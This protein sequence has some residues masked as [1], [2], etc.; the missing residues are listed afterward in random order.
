MAFFKKNLSVLLF[1][2]LVALLTLLTGNKY[3]LG[4]NS[5]DKNSERVI[6]IAFGD[7][8]TGEN[9]QYTLAAHLV[10]ECGQDCKGIFLLGDVI[11]PN[12][13][14]ALSDFQF[15]TKFEAPFANIYKPFYIVLGNHDY[16]GCEDCEVAYSSQSAK[17][18]LPSKY[19]LQSYSGVV[20]IF[21]IDTNDFSSEQKKWLIDGISRSKAKW[22]IVFGHHPLFSYDKRHAIAENPFRGM[23]EESICNNV[24]LYVSG[25]DH[26]LL[27]LGNYCNVHLMISGGGGA[28]LGTFVDKVPFALPEFGFLKIDVSSTRLEADLINLDG[29]KV[30]AWVKVK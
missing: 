9:I 14:K 22:K 23:I 13:V 12:G 20:D 2:V 24:D 8:G 10:M 16:D 17:W 1:I 15:K 5:V 30:H 18:H 27:D 3:L 11:Y 28:P 26:G 4:K 19:Y 21:V 25:H 29:K 7:T 6:L